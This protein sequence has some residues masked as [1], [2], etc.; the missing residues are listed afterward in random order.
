MKASALAIGLLVMTACSSDGEGNKA[1]G[2]TTSSGGATSAGGSHATGGST[3]TGGAS[4]TGGT[5]GSGGVATSG[6]ALGTGGSS[7]TGG[8][9]STGGNSHSGGSASAGGSPNAGGNNRGGSTG[10]GGTAGSSGTDGGVTDTGPSKQDSGGGCGECTTIKGG[11]TIG[12]KKRF[13]YG[14]NFAWKNFGCDFGGKAAWGY[15][16]VS[17]DK[18]GFTAAIKE[19][20]DNGVD[21]IRWWMFPDLRSDGIVLDSPTS[22]N[23]TGVGGTLL[24]DIDA[25]LSIAAE[26]DV[27]IVLTI[28]S[29]DNFKPDNTKDAIPGTM[30]IVVDSA[31]RSALINNV[32]VPVAKAVEASTNKDRMIAWDV[33]NEPEWAI[34]SGTDPYGDQAFDGQTSLQTITFAQMETFIKE[35]VTALHANSKA[36]VT[37]GS[38]AVKWANAWSKVGLDYHDFHWYGWVD[39]YFA[40][41]KTPADYKVDDQPVVVGEFPFNPSADTTGQSFGGISFGTLVG[42][43]YT[44]G[45]AGTMGWAY[46]DTTGGG[47]SW[48]SAKANVKAWADAHTCIHY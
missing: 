44:E 11:L 23:V 21:A 39:Q 4:S 9:T 1:T 12:C 35:M 24:A 41:T 17:G 20:K 28:F 37:V 18:E 2:G 36:L 25:A 30:D 6:G 46:S 43:F 27:H 38:A 16:G 15:K 47:F 14:A 42:D 5:V 22:K 29:F 7:G 32:V 40:H 33:I 34:T 10:S 13:L 45:Y 19:M 48:A 8:G 3:S 26:Q 31:K